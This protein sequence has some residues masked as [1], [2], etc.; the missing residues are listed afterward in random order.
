MKIITC[1]EAAHAP[2]ILAIFNVAIAKTTALYDYHPR[3]MANMAAWFADKAQGNYP[4]LGIASNNGELIAFGSY[5]LF[6]A[7]PAYKYSIEHSLYVREDQRGQGLGRLILAG[8]IDAA[9]KQ[10]YHTLIGVID[11]ENAPSI[12]LHEKFG[13]TSCGVIKQSGFKF[14]R[15]L[16]AAILQLILETPAAPV[17]G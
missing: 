13:F 10:G 16:D 14:G 6:R 1:N 8:L 12:A 7:R 15:W 2:A 3:T 5:G 17:D 4:V 11:S 9:R